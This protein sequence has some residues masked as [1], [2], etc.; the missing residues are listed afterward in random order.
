MAELHQDILEDGIKAGFSTVEAFGE[1][2]TG[3]EYE[4]F[5]GESSSLHSTETRRINVRAFWETGDPVGF[6]LSNPD[7]QA[8]KSAFNIVYSTNLPGEKPNFRDKLPKEVKQVSPSIYDD[9]F[10]SIDIHS[11]NELIDKINE[12]IISPAFQ[13]LKLKRIHLSKCLKKIYIANTNNLQAKYIKTNFSLVLHALQKNN[14]IVVKENR[15]FFQQLDPYKIISRAF[16][17][18]NSITETSLPLSKHKNIFLLLAPEASV[19]ILREFSHYFKVSVDKEITSFQYPAM[20]NII[21]NPF[22]DGQTGSV[23]F[24]DE[25]TQG[26]EKYLIR[27]GV[28][29]Q[30][31]TDIASAFKTGSVSTGN[32]FRSERTPVP[33]VRFSNLYINPTVLSLNNLMTDAGEGILVSL[34]KLK[35]VDKDGYVFSAYGYRFENDDILEP[36]HFYIQTT[37]KSYFLKILKISKEIKYFS[38]AYNIGSPYI[39]VEGTPKHDTMLQV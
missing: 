33:T 22:M 5:P 30:V 13:G 17:L 3:Q 11:F 34:L 39:L 26:Q 14:R 36:V 28:F 16:N 9:S 37:F 20:L 38:S 19:F 4:C 12:I 35:Q 6:S 15:V 21:D 27:K 29:N 18:L 10:Q 25:G 7:A 23:P 32:G 1:T 24:D 8:I 2:A 31:I